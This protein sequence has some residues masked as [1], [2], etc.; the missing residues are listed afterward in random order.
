MTQD[1]FS[2]SLRGRETPTVTGWERGGGRRHGGSGVE[3]GTGRILALPL[4]LRGTPAWF[5][6]L[7]AP[8]FPQ[9]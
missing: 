9:L 4:T 8:C 5:L 7:W 3:P 1:L 6:V 2:G